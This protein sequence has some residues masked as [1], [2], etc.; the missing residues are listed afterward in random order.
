[1]K[2]FLLKHKCA[3]QKDICTAIKACPTAAITY[4]EEENEPL[5][6]KILFDFEKCNECGKCA[7]ECCGQA[8]E[9]R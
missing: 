1:M 7:T 3:V 9:M 6:G 5:G 4:E 8:I 2:P